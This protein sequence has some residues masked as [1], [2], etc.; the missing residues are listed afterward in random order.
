MQI[1]QRSLTTFKADICQLISHTLYPLEMLVDSL[2]LIL[3]KQ[4]PLRSCRVP[5]NQNDPWYDAIKSDIIAAKNIVIGQKD[6][7]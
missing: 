7:S 5:I 3:E 2:R 4:A 1:F 6:S